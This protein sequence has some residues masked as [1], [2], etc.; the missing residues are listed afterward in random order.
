MPKRDNE[1]FSSAFHNYAIVSKIGEGGAGSVY[2]VTDEGL[3]HYA[4]KALDPN[5]ATS[6]KLLRFQNEVRF[7][8][9]TIHPHIVHVLDTGRSTA[10][11]SFYVMNLFPC[12]LQ[13]RI[14]K[15][16]PE[17]V[18]PVFAQIL[19]G[20]EAA[21]LRSAIHR[22]LKPQNVL[23]DPKKNVLVVADF[24][25][26]SFAEED[27]Y[28]AVET[29]RLERL[30]NFQYA[31]PEQR[32]R[33][34]EVTSKVDIYA[35]GLM[36]NQMFTSEIP[37]GTQY[38]TIESVAPSF[39]FLDEMVEQMLRQD[40]TQRPSI[41]ETK[42]QLIARQQ[43]F[44]SLQK[45]NELT[46]QVVPAGEITDPLISDPIQVQSTD[47]R[48]GQL[49]FT[50]TQQPS[51]LWIHMFVHQATTQFVGY[52]PDTVT[53]KGR[54]AS[55]PT[56]EA[57]ALQQRSYFEGWIRNANGLYEQEIKRNLQS[58]K[59]QLEQELQQQLAKEQERQRILRLV[60]P[61]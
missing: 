35:L 38:K 37:H 18:L 3:I 34:R 7:C 9:Q 45:I 54:V 43:Q 25:I 50:L 60:N 10:G 55:V 19:D 5:K 49:L 28:V 32:A 40:A 1:V 22:D 14:G 48:D 58:E 8:Q 33:D 23:C 59:R 61:S 31:A 46:K 53:F 12:T 21:H 29:E 30:A 13:D 51:P 41:H 15:L 39:S 27:L 36:L 24:G 57:F 47:Y 44:I 17:E 4:L 42:K 6:Q 26:A 11:R 20:V 16:K 52:G 2:E 56:K